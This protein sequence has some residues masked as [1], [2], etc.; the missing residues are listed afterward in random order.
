MKIRPV[1]DELFRAEVWTD[2]MKLTV[3]LHNFVNTPKKKKRHIQAA[4]TPAR[5]DRRQFI[6]G[7]HLV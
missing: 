6:Q 3:V 1:R 5:H 4:A 2:A 7:Q